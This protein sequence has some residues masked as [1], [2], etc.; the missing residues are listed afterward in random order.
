MWQGSASQGLPNAIFTGVLANG[1][2]PPDGFNWNSGSGDAP[3]QDDPRLFDENVKS[4]VD[5]FVKAA[6]D[7]QTNYRTNH[8]L[9]TMGS[10]FEVLK[11]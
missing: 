8:I 7:Q 10:D 6:Q 9:M 2:G 3:I 4:R 11:K 5:D 1:Y